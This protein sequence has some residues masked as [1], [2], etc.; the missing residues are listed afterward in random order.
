MY[1]SLNLL[2]TYIG[3]NATSN[4]VIKEAIN[5]F[6]GNVLTPFI[7]QFVQLNQKQHSYRDFLERVELHESL[8]EMVAVLACHILVEMWIRDRIR[9]C[10]IET[11]SFLS[12]FLWCSSDSSIV[13]S[14]YYGYI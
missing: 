3:E 4:S 12:S 6:Q 14:I 5:S 2:C 11:N 1:R 7:S 8:E 10:D 13:I 9:E